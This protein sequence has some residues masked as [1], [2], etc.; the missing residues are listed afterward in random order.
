ADHD[1]I[2][3]RYVPIAD[4]FWVL[5]KTLSAG[6]G[7]FEVYHRGRYRVSTLKGSDL[8]GTY[9][10][11]LKGIMTPEDPGTL[12]GTL[13]G[14]PLTNKP[15]ELCEGTH[16]IECGTDCQPAVVWMGPKLDRIHRI[17]PGDHRQLFVNWY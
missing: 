6:G 17:G 13:D 7:T 8:D 4:D 11:G 10:L 12:Q 1:F 5:G 2:K 16:R 3:Q 14:A 15:I 9:A